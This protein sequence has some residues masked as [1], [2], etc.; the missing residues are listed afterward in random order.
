MIYFT[1]N[2]VEFKIRFRHYLEKFSYIDKSGKAT[3]QYRP[4]SSETYIFVDEKIIG[5]GFAECSKN[6][7]FEYKYGRK[8]SLQRALNN[9]PFDS[10]TRAN[11][12]RK[13]FESLKSRDKKITVS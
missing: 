12:W 2:G 11:V 10:T 9:T 3:I 1:D 4:V 13:Y 5:K 6:D 7:R 8:L